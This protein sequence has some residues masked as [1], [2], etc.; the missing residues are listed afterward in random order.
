MRKMGNPLIWISIV[1][2]SI[3]GIQFLTTTKPAK[4]ELQRSQY[5]MVAH[6]YD[7]GPAIDQVVIRVDTPMK[8]ENLSKDTFKVSNSNTYVE[9][10]PREVTKAFLSDSKGNPTDSASSLFITL[11]MTVGPTLNA[12]RAVAYQNDSGLS[13]KTKIQFDIQQQQPLYTAQSDKIENIN[14]VQ[15]PADPLTPQAD[16]F[17]PERQF[18]YQDKHFGAQYMNYT[19]FSPANKQKHALVIWLH[20]AG[21]GGQDNNLVGLYGTNLVDLATNKFQKYFDGGFDILVP[22]ARTYWMD[23][24]KTTVGNA[25]VQ[26]GLGVKDTTSEDAI[27]QNSRYENAVKALIQSYLTSHPNIDRDRIYIGGCSNGGYLAMK[28]LIDD[29]DKYSAVFPIC[30]GL[31]DKNVSDEDIQSIKNTPIWFTQSANDPVLDPQIYTI[32]TYKRLITAGAKNT[33]FTLLNGVY[34]KTGNYKDDNGQPHEYSGHFSWL[35]VLDDY[36]ATEFDGTQTKNSDGT[37]TT[38]FSWLSQQKKSTSWK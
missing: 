34:D 25:N 32:P 23:T 18:T 9:S 21:Q 13:I 5:T 8:A 36:P 20:G 31:L 29:P 19:S 2:M 33:H 16:K 38:V 27:K 22:Q 11:D 7:W 17:S 30:E 24:N 3:C 6:A 10:T 12:A 37:D 26:G 28:M 1:L 14:P 15:G 35:N 4:A